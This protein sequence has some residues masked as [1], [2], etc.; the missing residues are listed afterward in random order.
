MSRTPGNFSLPIVRGATWEDEFIYKDA[1]G[2]VVNLTG[3][4]ARMQIRTIVGQFGITT[5]TS[6]LLALSTAGVSPKCS[7]S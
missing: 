7:S 2:V 3:Y 5:T 1:A 6:L 4:H